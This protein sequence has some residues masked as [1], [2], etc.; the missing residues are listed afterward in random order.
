MNWLCFNGFIFVLSMGAYM[1]GNNVLGFAGALYFF[2]P[3]IGMSLFILIGLSFMGLVFAAVQLV[4][5]KNMLS[6]S[7]LLCGLFAFLINIWHMNS[8]HSI[9]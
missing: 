1:V 6:V 5:K 3:T 7:A 9:N 8:F 4:M 2:L